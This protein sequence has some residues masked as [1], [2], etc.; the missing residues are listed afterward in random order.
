VSF[1]FSSSFCFILSSCHSYIAEVFN[2]RVLYYVAG[3]T[4]PSRVYGQR[5]RC[6][7]QM[8]VCFA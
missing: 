3:S 8:V 7:F 5:E 2:N 6:L 1:F 4:S